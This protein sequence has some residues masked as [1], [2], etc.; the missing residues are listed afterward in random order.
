MNWKDDQ[1]LGP[2]AF[3]K[4][5]DKF[6]YANN[7]RFT[8]D[9][10]D[11]NK[12]HPC[13]YWY[14][15]PAAS[16]GYFFGEDNTGSSSESIKPLFQKNPN[17]D[18]ARGAFLSNLKNYGFESF[19]AFAHEQ[20]SPLALTF[21]GYANA[22]MSLAGEVYDITQH[23]PIYGCVNAGRYPIHGDKYFEVFTS[24]GFVIDFAEPMNAFGM[25]MVDIGDFGATLTVAMVYA[26]GSTHEIEL[27][28]TYEEIPAGLGNSGGWVQ[29]VGLFDSINPFVSVRMTMDI[30]GV[31]VFAFDAFYIAR[32][33]D[34]NLERPLTQLIWPGETTTLYPSCWRASGALETEDVN[35]RIIV[36]TAD[37][38]NVAD[39]FNQLR[40]MFSVQSAAAPFRLKIDG[41]SIG[42]RDGS[43]LNF[44]GAPTRIKWSSGNNLLL[45]TESPCWEDYNFSDWA[46]LIIDTTKEYLIHLW[47][48]YDGTDT[49]RLR[50]DWP[51]RDLEIYRKLSSVDDTMVE[52]I[53]G[54]SL[55]SRCLH[56][57]EIQ[58]R[59]SR[60]YQY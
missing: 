26:D 25:Y 39:N 23:P 29:F 59:D 3:N 27:P 32:D 5:S 51:A 44:L 46:N 20:N 4:Q 14:S 7:P 37:W 16:R 17:A 57:R 35:Y 10:D 55:Q 13:G 11:P 12:H 21:G 8:A 36:T 47:I 48:D 19:E 31:D 42:I 49:E 22:T 2:W 41:M 18:A 45:T 52:T 1:D 30:S 56:L 33:G 43:T 28:I 15:D 50:N 34:I 38:F 9:P 53:S 24:E 58:M 60:Q 40:F 54:Y 6:G